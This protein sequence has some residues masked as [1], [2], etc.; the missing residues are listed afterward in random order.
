MEGRHFETN[1]L[2]PR[3][4]WNA[5]GKDSHTELLGHPAAVASRRKHIWNNPAARWGIDSAAYP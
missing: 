3:W 2:V 4:R 1:P 5:V